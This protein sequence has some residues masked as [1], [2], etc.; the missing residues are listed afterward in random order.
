MFRNATLLSEVCSIA[1]GCAAIQ[2]C[3]RNVWKPTRNPLVPGF[4]QTQKPHAE[5]LLYVSTVMESPS[6]SQQTWLNTKASEE[7][8]YCILEPA[9]SISSG[10]AVKTISKC[11]ACLNSSSRMS[12]VLSGCFLASLCV[13]HLWCVVYSSQIKHEQHGHKPNDDHLQHHINYH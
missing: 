3:W 9:M 2:H 12:K 6:L 7:D 1:K 4:L 10:S 5:K 11:L 13:N 8:L